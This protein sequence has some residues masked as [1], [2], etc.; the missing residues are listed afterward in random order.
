VS[1]FELSAYHSSLEVVCA[2]FESPKREGDVHVQQPHKSFRPLFMNTLPV[3]PP[4]S[5]AP[6]V[7]GRHQDPPISFSLFVPSTSMVCKCALQR[8]SFAY[9]SSTL[10]YPLPLSSS[11]ISDRSLAQSYSVLPISSPIPFS[12]SNSCECPPTSSQT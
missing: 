12:L 11:Y 4:E 5:G 8:C 9:Q 10:L 7:T 3:P 6:Y 2:E 1:H